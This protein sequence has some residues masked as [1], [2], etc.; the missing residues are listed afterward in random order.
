MA[1]RS[2][3]LAREAALRA[4]YE[5]EIGRTPPAEAIENSKADLDLSPDNAQYSAGIVNGVVKNLS[6]LDN[7]IAKYVRG[8]DYDRLAVIDRNILR[9]AAYEILE[10]PAVPPKVS[11]N[12]AVE[13]AKKFSTLE[14]GKFI[15]G[16]LARL[17][18]DTP[19]ANWDPHQAPPDQ[20]IMVDEPEAAGED[21][22]MEEEVVSE[23]SEDAVMARKFGT[24]TVRTEQ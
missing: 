3:R 6:D 4:L 10:L 17:L 23:D 7:R 1:I 19:K 11:I 15:N 8:Y 13:V 18:L 21:A 16:V 24:W 14:G 12:E 2:R 22:V 9:I 5:I 20:E